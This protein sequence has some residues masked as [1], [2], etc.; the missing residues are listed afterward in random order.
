MNDTSAG[1]GSKEFDLQPDTRVLPMLGEINIDQWRCIAELVDNAIDGFLNSHRAG[2]SITGPR[3][4]V[5]LPNADK[6]GAQL[7]IT[8]NGGGMSPEVLERAVRAGWSG[9]NPIDNLGLFG[10]GFNIATARLG[11]VTEVWTTRKGEAEWH[12]L[13][14]DFDQLRSQRHFKTPHLR[15][16]KADIDQHGTEVTIKRL[17]PEQRKWLARPANQ[18]GVRKRLSQT[19]SSMLRK[20]GVPISFDLF[21]NNK[22]VEGLRHCT[23]SEDRKVDLPDL[24]TVH[25][26]IPINH[27]M[28]QR[29]YCTNCMSWL[30]DVDP[31]A[32]CPICI[33][34]GTVTKRSRKVTGWIGI[35]RYRNQNEFGLDFIRNGRKIEISNKDLFIYRGEDGEE[36][37][38]P[39]DDPRNEGRIVGEIHIDHCR[40]SYA[41]DRFDRTDPSWDE[42]VRLIRG[43]GPLRPEKAKSL[44]Y[45]Q[46]DAPL[47]A[48]FKAFRRT[49]P[50]SKTAGAY[51][52]IMIVKDNA[53]ASE[54]ANLFHDGNP[55]YQDDTKWWELVEEADRELL[56]GT[57][58]KPKSDDDDKKPGETLPAGLLD[59]DD[60]AKSAL[61]ADPQGSTPEPPKPPARR[62]IPS[63]SRKYLYQKSNTSWPVVAFEVASTDPQL[64]GGSPWV[65]VLADVATRTYHFLYD[66]AH[67]VFHSITMTPRDA[68]LTDL[69]W[70]TGELLRTSQEGPKLGEIL[71]ELR[72]NYGDETLLDAKTMGADASN[73]LTDI[74]RA[75]VQSCKEEDRAALFNELTVA[76]QQMV[77]RA[78]AA[79]KIKPTDVTGDGSFLQYAPM[80]ILRSLIEQ[81]PEYCF[82]GKI[83]DEPYESLDYG[84]T[85]ITDGVRSGIV[86]KYIGLLNDAIWLSRQDSSDLVN[87]PREELIRATMSLRL[88]RPDAEPT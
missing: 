37:E 55:E 78:L 51:A 57:G 33:S 82:E 19:Y 2:D 59:P 27:S 54:M 31:S 68:L 70:L 87:A 74:A 35:Q 40:V 17:K 9:N 8:D 84:D 58:G 22:R 26:V 67:E 77:M 65:T 88:L 83:W 7:K 81:H 15:R 64:P 53:R 29:F 16:P 52:R 3:V 32:P 36:R 34:K 60:S 71:A 73:I 46:N 49:S 69:A 61:P 21:I 25:A 75:F 76:N 43:E 5:T 85:E 14:I 13:S 39:I 6:E 30:M 38:Y 50:H 23:W 41:K 79:K 10:M 86:S 12:G 80:E 48:L 24:G 56:Y 28:A 63:L 62:E 72:S 42:M 47:F 1:A 4:D 45:S 20:N 18:T 66:P 44:G 11:S